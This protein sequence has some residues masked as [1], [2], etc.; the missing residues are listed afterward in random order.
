M[1][2]SGASCVM[3]NS[4][5]YGKD[6]QDM[7]NS[8]SI[9]T[10]DSGNLPAT[11]MGG[12]V[13]LLSF[14]PKK[15]QWEC[16]TYRD[17]LLVPSLVT[18][19]IGTKS[20]THAQG[21]VIFEE[22]LVTVQDKHSHTI[23]VPTSGDS[24]SAVAMVIWDNSM[25][26]PA[27]TLAFTSMMT[28]TIHPHRPYN[29]ADLWHQR[30]GHASHDSIMQTQAVTLSHNIPSTPATNPGVLCNV[31]ICSKA[32]TKDVAHPRHVEKPLKLVSMDVM[33]PL[34]GDTKFA[35]ALIIHDAYSGMSWAQGLASK[36]EASQEAAWWFSEISHNKTD[37]EDIGFATLMK[38][39]AHSTMNSEQ[40]DGQDERGVQVA[41][42][43]KWEWPLSVMKQHKDFPSTRSK[44]SSAKEQHHKAGRTVRRGSREEEEQCRRRPHRNQRQSSTAVQG[45][46]NQ[47]VNTLDT[48]V[49]P[50]QFT[51]DLGVTSTYLLDIDHAELPLDR[52][53]PAVS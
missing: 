6:W 21:R 52:G 29:K 50:T 25:P 24:Y 3:V 2:D 49:E 18:N 7:E 45:S 53:S 42:Q 44:G 4:P 12:T 33:G 41:T 30:L 51:P 48:H 11:K 13:S 26:E 10:A 31:C 9:T 35:Y 34:H 23:H 27:V 15:H 16:M 17:C 36:G 47:S 19:L 43:M 20:V 22:E 38:Q 32:I 1:F 39:G 8:V 40:E 37:V 46:L 5:K 14:S 28:N